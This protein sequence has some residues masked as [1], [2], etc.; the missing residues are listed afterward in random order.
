MLLVFK[1]IR[2]VIDVDVVLKGAVL[3]A[4]THVIGTKKLGK[5]NN[6]PCV[7]S[8]ISKAKNIWS[9]DDVSF[10]SFHFILSMGGP[11]I[12]CL[13]FYV[14]GRESHVNKHDECGGDANCTKSHGRVIDTGYDTLTVSVDHDAATCDEHDCS[15]EQSHQFSLDCHASHRSCNDEEEHDNAEATC[16]GGDKPVIVNREGYWR[17]FDTSSSQANADDDVHQ[18]DQF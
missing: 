14:F 9:N 18:C 12:L 7:S 4:L 3:I 17:S 6:L 5:C 1:A 2:V 10:S 15:Q 8:F 13:F 16:R 11:Y